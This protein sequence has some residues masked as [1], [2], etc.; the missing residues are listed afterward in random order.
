M[1]SLDALDQALYRAEVTS[2]VRRSVAIAAQQ[3]TV[4]RTALE[5]GK[6]NLG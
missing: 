3:A 4:I 2:V 6:I 1:E 5:E